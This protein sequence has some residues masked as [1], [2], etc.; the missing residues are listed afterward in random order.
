MK[1]QE[2]NPDPLFATCYKVRF[3][4]T[5]LSTTAFF[6]NYPKWLDSIAVID[7]LAH[8]GIDWQELLKR[9][10]DVAIAHISFDFLAPLFLNDDV[11][12]AVEKVQLGNKS[13]R[14][15]GSF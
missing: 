3:Y 11:E 4:D 9:N 7:Y 5:D 10:I 13:I 12:M 6:S 8:K 14:I 2:T 15:S 1:K